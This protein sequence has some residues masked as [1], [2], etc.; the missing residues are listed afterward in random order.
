MPTVNG[1]RWVKLGGLAAGCVAAYFAVTYA[2]RVYRVRRAAASLASVH[3]CL[4]GAPLLPKEEASARLHR[5]M[6]GHPPKGWPA[7]CEKYVRDYEEVDEALE[8]IDLQAPSPVIDVDTVESSPYAFDAYFG[9]RPSTRPPPDDVPAAPPYADVA[10]ERTTPLALRASLI[11][12]SFDPVPGADLHFILGG[13]TLCESRAPIGKIACRPG[14]LVPKSVLAGSADGAPLLVAPTGQQ[15]WHS[16]GDSVH[17]A[18]DARPFCTGRACTAFGESDGSV[19]VLSRQS[20]NPGSDST[21]SY[22]AS[23][24]N[25]PLVDAKWTTEANADVTLLGDR[26]VW[27]EDAKDGTR[28]LFA[29]RF[30]GTTASGIEDIGVVPK[31]SYF[32]GCFVRD[33]LTIYGPGYVVFFHDDEHSPV[34]TFTIPRSIG[35]A[36]RHSAAS[37]GVDAV[38]FTSLVDASADGLTLHVARCTA[39]GCAPV[40]TVDLRKAFSRLAEPARPRAPSDVRAVGLGDAVVVVWRSSR[41]GVRYVVAKPGDIDKTEDRPIYDDT[42]SGGEPFMSSVIQDDFELVARRD[43]AVLFVETINSNAGVKA[44]RIARDGKVTGL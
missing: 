3:K 12:A 20:S 29:R 28:H 18:D 31:P 33:A 26:A 30:V 39:R 10:D 22:A 17:R 36:E 9:V 5:I 24:G 4:F 15:D 8:G 27:L 43:A 23:R 7:R 19:L 44:F 40:D 14:A 6:L 41:R 38:T 1:R 37:C 34:H 13:T 16:S 32:A 25:G 2:T 35:S 21:F 11:G 42:T